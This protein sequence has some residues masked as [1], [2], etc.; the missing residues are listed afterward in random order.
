MKNLPSDTK[1]IDRLHRIVRLPSSTRNFIHNKWVL[2]FILFTG[3]FGSVVLNTNASATRAGAMRADTP[4]YQRQT[5]ANI[6]TFLPLIFTPYNIP[7]SDGDW[8]M[9]AANSQR[10]SW[11]IEEVRGDLNVDWYHPVEPYIPYKVQP[12]AAN[13]NI[14]VSTARGLYTFKASD[15]NLLWVYPTQ[16]PLGN[17]PTIATINGRSIA[18]VGGYDRK[19]HAIDAISG[20]QISG[21]TPY[22]AAAGF[23]TNPLVINNTIYAGNRDGYF[24]AFNAGTG[25]LVWR[26]KTE[27]PIL[28]SAAL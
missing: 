4:T 25:S 1:A 9:V 8:P 19:I 7:P 16:L 14:Y 21:Y 15:G 11:T 6:Q 18:Y 3:I 22:E 10:T 13:G 5:T 17:S 24:Y 28:F 27:G 20:E 26:Y 23:E 12:I 2:I